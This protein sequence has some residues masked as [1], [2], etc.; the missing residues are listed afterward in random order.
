MSTDHKLTT[1]EMLDA[2]GALYT[3]EYGDWVL[4]VHHILTE[5]TCP[6]ASIAPE[7][8]YERNGP[9]FGG[10]QA[11]ADTI[12]GAVA[13]AVLSAYSVLIQRLPFRPGVPW[14]NFADDESL[15]GIIAAL[16]AQVRS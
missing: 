12:E 15:K 11:M 8:W 16:D 2:L 4:T 13:A 9:E 14:T 10:F 7:D 1:D 5:P 3:P 6:S